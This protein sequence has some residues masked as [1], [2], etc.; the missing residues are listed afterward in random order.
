MFTSLTIPRRMISFLYLHPI[1]V[2]HIRFLPLASAPYAR[3]SPLKV[4][5]ENFWS[6]EGDSRIHLE[7]YLGW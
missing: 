5:S 3:I 7:H 6:K 4:A 2:V 1:G